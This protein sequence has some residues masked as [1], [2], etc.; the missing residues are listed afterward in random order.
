[1][2][3]PLIVF[4][5]D[6]SID[7]GTGHVMRCLTLADALSLQGAE[8]RFVCR[9]LPGNLNELIERRGHAVT[10]LPPSGQAMD[11]REITGDEQGPPHAA[12]LGVDWRVD[13]E[14]T[15]AVF[16]DGVSEW[17]VVDHYALD[18]RWESYLRDCCHRLMVI[19]DLADR[20]HVSDLLL[21]QN[22][23]RKAA[24]YAGLTPTECVTLVGPQFALLRPEFASLRDYSLARRGLAE[25]GSLL[26][27]LGG[28][29]KGNMTS[30][31]LDALLECPLP[32]R[33]RIVVVMGPSAP[34][35]E[36]VR[37]RAGAMPWATEVRV[38]VSDMATLMADSDIAI[39]AAGTTAW[40]RACLAL[41]TLA[42][43]AA[44]NQRAGAE[45][46]DAAGCIVKL[47]LAE[48]FAE[49][50]REKL[51][52]LLPLEQRRAMAHACCALTDGGGCV[53]LVQQLLEN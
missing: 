32:E 46:L 25:V 48:D 1:M 2:G 52:A 24:D 30:L 5:A 26:V 36:T 33:C 18:R 13:A 7:I 29:D 20:A 8:C 47:E 15:R 9:Q 34:W 44:D 41:P 19:D 39:G 22:L 21:D 37:G 16:A 35:L 40:E 14:Q 11:E 43:V 12:W 38:N 51:A 50:L 3:R 53:R 4:R 42:V 6:A 31:V 17:L 10:A 27:T 49:E 23:G 45:A 28:V